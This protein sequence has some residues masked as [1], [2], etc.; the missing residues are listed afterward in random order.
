MAICPRTADFVL[1]RKRDLE[2]KLKSSVSDCLDTE[3]TH[4]FR[5]TL[6]AVKLTFVVNV[7]DKESVKSPPFNLSRSQ[8]HSHLHYD[9]PG[10]LE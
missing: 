2:P 8:D 1:T 3:L 10:G 4:F 5:V 7:T 6:G 9:G